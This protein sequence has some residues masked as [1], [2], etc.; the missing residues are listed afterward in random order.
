M[1]KNKK[2][3]QK[4]IVRP[5]TII[6]FVFLLLIDRSVYCIIAPL[7]ALIHEAG[8]FIAMWAFGV[9]VSCFE[10]SLFGAE[11]R[12]DFKSRGS[13]AASVI[14]K[15]IIYS[16]GALANLISGGIC[17]LIF[18]DTSGVALFF[19]GC[20]LSLAL[21]NMLPIRTLDGGAVIDVLVCALPSSTGFYIK[22]ILEG[23]SLAFIFIAAISLLLFFNANISL[24]ILC[25]YLFYEIY[26]S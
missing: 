19:Q 10:I 16:A 11:I 17:F 26:L 8:H 4:F 5:P 22:D 18:R 13:E 9:D 25:M 20:S 6:F 1:E 7:A 14:K 23:I 12:T 3:K 21:I 15:I 24:L 2:K